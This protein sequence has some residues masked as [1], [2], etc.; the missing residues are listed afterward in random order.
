MRYDAC[1]LHL[2]R[3]RIETKGKDIILRTVHQLEDINSTSAEQS[4]E[5]M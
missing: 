5:N 4:T 3:F 2:K 1:R